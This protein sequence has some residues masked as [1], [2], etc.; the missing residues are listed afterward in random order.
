MKY[1]NT[2]GKRA[3]FK[4]LIQ[5]RSVQSAIMVLPPGQSSSD[6]AENEH[7]KSEQWLYVIAGSARAVV[8]R[9]TLKIKTGALLLIEKNEPHRITNAGRAPLVTLNFYVPP[10]YTRSGEVRPAIATH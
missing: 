9:R 5:S 1:I 2:I 4:P 10:A 8:G 7:P 6:G 3:L